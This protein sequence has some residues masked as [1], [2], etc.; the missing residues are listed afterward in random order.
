MKK[1]AVIDYGIGN[2]YSVTKALN[3]FTNDWVVTEDPSVIED[4]SAIIL[5]G[6]GAFHAG[7]KGLKA[8]KL[9][10][11]L[12]KFA[13][14]GKPVL[15]ICLGAQILLSKGYEFGEYEGLG[16]IEG[17]TV[18]FPKLKEGTKIPHI[19]WNAVYGDKW[20][21]TILD[22]IEKD[23][24]M[25]FVHSF[26]LDPENEEDIFTLSEYGGHEFVSAIKKGN[27]YGLQFHPE[28]SAEYGL[29]IIKNFVELAQICYNTH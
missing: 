5:P 10:Q 22:N 6:V 8:R 18:P 1:I 7:M 13:Q 23:E 24:D 28:K 2:I 11:P 19:G 4:A 29:S 14:S 17:S 3:K 20:K 26:I 16:I 15:G 27:V 9:T 21:D 25:Y 12:K